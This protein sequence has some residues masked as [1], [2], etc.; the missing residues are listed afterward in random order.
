MFVFRGA[1]SDNVNLK[2][3]SC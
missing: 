1:D 3:T 2:D